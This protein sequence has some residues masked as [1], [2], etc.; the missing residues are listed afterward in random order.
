M[1]P[2]YLGLV[3]LA[4][5][6]SG[7]FVGFP[8][9][10]TLVILA[11]VF[12]YIGF[13]P[14]VF[15]LMVFQT[16]GL[17]YTSASNTAFVTGMN[18]IFVPLLGAL[19]YGKRL[20][21]KLGMSVLLAGVGL[22]FLC[23]GGDWSLNKG[24]LIVIVCAV[25]I[26]FQIIYTARFVRNC[27]PYWLTAVQ[28]GTVALFSTLCGWTRGVDVFFWEPAVLWAMFICVVF[29]T[30]F[31][32]LVQTA[33]QRFTSPTKTALIFCLEPV[34]GALYAHLFAGETLGEWGGIGALC[35]VAAMVMAELPG[36]TP[37]CD[38]ECSR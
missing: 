33:M 13:G 30:V 36:R 27:D 11:I 24:D 5:L 23:T 20:D 7:I 21:I 8:I 38:K 17:M 32:F 35:I 4:A 6:L 29:A 26:A 1:S 2:E 22:F 12:G 9:A 34:F 31:A 14:T 18:V 28:I 3:L 10:F 15:Y 19:F 37:R 16:I 25:C